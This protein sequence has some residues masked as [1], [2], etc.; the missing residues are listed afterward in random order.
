MI[1]KIVGLARDRVEKGR[2]EAAETFI[3][4]Y[5]RHVPP[6]D[7]LAEEVS[8][9][10]GAV[11]ALWQ[12]GHER[13]AGR[14]RLR[15]INPR[16]EEHG[17]HT[18]H[19]VVEIVNDDMPFLV[20]SVTQALNQLGLTV[21]LVIHPVIA[22]ERDTRGKMIGL[23]DPAESA[24]S[25]KPD[26]TG[27]GKTKAKTA[28]ADGADLRESFMHIE[29]DEQTSADSLARIEQRIA[30]VLDDVRAAVEDWRPMRGR[31]HALIEEL[32]SGRLPVP[33]D[34]QTEVKAFLE[35]LDDDHFTFL[36]YRDYVFE[37]AG[38]DAAMAIV[39]DSGL[40]VLRDPDVLL[41]E[42]MR[43]HFGT[44]PPDVKAFITAPSAIMVT[45]ANRLSTVHRSVQLDTII[46]KRFDGKGRV[47][48]EQQFAGLFTSVAYNRSARDIPYLRRK[49]RRVLE[50]AG[51]DPAS[52]DGKAL[53]NILDTYPR[54]EL[55]QISDQELLDTAIGVLHLQ[56]R[57]R[58]ALFVR[59]DPFERF[60]S[61]LVYVPR[62]RYDTDLRR[63]MQAILERSFDGRVTAF[64]TQLS[65]GVHARVHFIVK[66]TPG[67][68]P[69][70]EPTDI[71]GALVEAGRSWADH[72]QEALIDA[73]GEER[74]LALLRRYRDAFSTFYTETAQPQAAV[75]DIDRIETVLE[76]GAVGLSL[77]RPI[78][79]QA[80]EVRFKLYNAGRPVP[81]S[82][83]L[84]M[85]ENMGLKV[86]S[87]NPF[88]VTPG[89]DDRSLWLHDFVMET[90]DG[91][92]IELG[93]VKQ[94]FQ[95]AFRRVWN[96]EMEDD[97]FNRLVVGAG[98]AWR[99][100]V[101]LRAY[102]KYLR[103]A[104]IGFSQASLEDTLGAYPAITGL[105][106]RLFE[107]RFDPDQDDGRADRVADLDASI[108][109]ALD[110]VA[111]LDEDRILRRFVNLVQATL[112]TNYF[113]PAA[114][115]AD[116]PYISFKLAS[117]TIDDLP[118]PRPWVEV[119]VYSPRVEAVHLR[120]GKVARGGIRWS[121]RREDFRTEILGLMKAQM[122]K[123]AV[124]VPVGSKGGFV[125]KRPPR[126]GGREALQ[127]EGIA[128]YKTMMRGLLDVTDNMVAADGG[129]TRVVHPDR[130]V[131]YDDADPYLVVAA[132]KGT[133]TFSDIANGVSQDYGFWL[134]DA[135]ASGGSA[136]YDHKKMGITARGAWES[137]KRHFRELGLDTQS[138]SFT[139]VGCGDMSGD[140][141]GNGMLLSEHIKLVGA[142]N[143]LHIFV[144]PDPDPAK[145]FK[146]RQRLF[147]AGRG[148][149]D[150]YDGKL[151]SKGGGVFDRSA[152]A[153]KTTPEMRKLFGIDAA[154]LTPNELIS[155]MLKA[156][157]D[158][159]WFGG[160]GT[161]VKSSEEANAAVGDKAN[162]SLRV[163]GRQVRARVI[164]EGANLGVTQ[165]GR[166]EYAKEGGPL[167]GAGR[168]GRIN[169]DF[170]D[171]SAGVDCSDHEVNI[172]ILTGQ[173]IRAGDMTLK[174]RNQLLEKMT[175]EVARLVLRDNYLQ[176]QA[177]TLSMAEAPE[178]LDQQSRFMKALEKAGKL[179]RAVEDLP[180]D[181]TLTERL[182]RREGLTRPELCVLLSYAKITLYDE[183]LASDLPD[184]P[185]LADDLVRYF[186]EPLQKRHA[187]WIRG[188]TLKREI[189]A[190]ATVNS[191]INR[192]G[193]TFMAE[194]ADR[195]GMG[196][197][198]ITRAYIVVRD[199]FDL[200]D[201]WARIEA[202]DAKVDAA[203]QTRMVQQTRKLVDRATSWMLRHVGEHLDIGAQIAHFRPGIEALRQHLDEVLY[204]EAREVVEQR[205]AEMTEAGV[206]DDLA[207]EIAALNLIAAGLDLIHIADVADTALPRVGPV[208]FDL[209]RRL[210]L[211]WLRD[212]AIRMQTGNHWQKQ[213]VAAIVDDL[214]ALQA[215]L[216]VRVLETT[217][218]AGSGGKAKTS[219]KGR[220]KAAEAAEADWSD[221]ATLDVW[222]ERRRA[223][224]ERID[225]L[226]AEL[227]ALD[228]VDLSML[229]VANRRLRSLMAG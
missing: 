51:V 206:P 125:V 172:K 193:P 207:Q 102:A 48:G 129:E 139:V 76:T 58:T 38:E 133:A 190:T 131:R 183:L 3:R 83:V 55:F 85:L 165:P 146:E 109:Q 199:S 117:A 224:I 158:L 174:Q 78:E 169:T 137:V 198:D 119:F 134:D 226:I 112:R 31:M 213:A 29:V 202:L 212:S 170:I 94:A 2:V 77:Y 42:G 97:G 99:E 39:E 22:V 130:V 216:T 204:D 7:M 30:A 49:V 33:E 150:Q 53:A 160:I 215:D 17:W 225:Q 100:V 192:T 101:L 114:D 72:L 200:R 95:E 228:H 34:E 74:G 162:D 4:L 128:C 154:Q 13:K 10:Y 211:A 32:G 132:D 50:M 60:M 15:A 61:C 221:G 12:F 115:G 220:R 196:A 35:W 79:A 110:D 86:V 142:F 52:H 185:F 20:D 209:G 111:N 126:G 21:H 46:V 11:I 56:E 120:G 66:T 176:T 104:R 106:V 145:T 205:K 208:Y 71:E 65:E 195:T 1:E 123:N 44:L 93:P 103:Q 222:V 182:G 178:L 149:W 96:G 140:V 108:R 153:I 27:K 47:V 138:Q 25:A 166:I 88:E 63:K 89:G 151:I 148:S 218:A 168:G 26:K 67:E 184:D 152:K 217:G 19:T 41:F 186:P 5:Y 37:G 59:K 36:G 121:D 159:L 177:L 64:Y 80:R 191:V 116:K 161:Y 62:D 144:D 127:A 173:V 181:E 135:F 84:P 9:L 157:V 54:D 188:H 180:D 45:K 223:P 107:A 75:L 28:K 167:N 81:L 24:D 164:G 124:I 113:Q 201:L 73:K 16:F 197:A 229:A 227:R 155:A 68:I 118:L 40:G 136:G 179:N 203:V 91:R 23:R 147:E 194:T 175:E 105:I 156:P 70:Y 14:P 82:D 214:Y 57:Q 69:D 171:N 143:H 219:G 189:I 141:F 210:G 122:V 8:D 18:S 92:P 98:L 87:E 6:D 187:D 163:D 90:R 43:K